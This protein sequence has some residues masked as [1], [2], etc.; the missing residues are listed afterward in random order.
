MRGLLFIFGRFIRFYRSDYFAAD[1]YAATAE[2]IWARL[3][4]GV[5]AEDVFFIIDVDHSVSFADAAQL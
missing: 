2:A 4:T 1:G 5:H 3:Q